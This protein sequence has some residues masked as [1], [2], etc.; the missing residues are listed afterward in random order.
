MVPASE[1]SR[2]STGI[3]E[4]TGDASPMGKIYTECI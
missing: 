2:R 4:S 3:R 1:Q